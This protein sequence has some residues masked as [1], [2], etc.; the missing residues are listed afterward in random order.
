M[1]SETEIE[2]DYDALL[3]NKGKPQAVQKPEDDDY[4]EEDA[5]SNQESPVK[6]VQNHQE[7]NSDLGNVYD[8]EQ[9][10]TIK[11]KGDNIAT[12]IAGIRAQN[13]LALARCMHQKIQTSTK[14]I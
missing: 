13:K 6:K 1:L 10:L 7:S 9:T 2:D 12:T 4:Y 5:K 3:K 14:N 8:F 11:I